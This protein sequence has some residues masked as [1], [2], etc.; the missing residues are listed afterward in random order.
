MEALISYGL[1]EQDF[2]TLLSQNLD[3]DEIGAMP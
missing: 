2:D 1:S 3:L